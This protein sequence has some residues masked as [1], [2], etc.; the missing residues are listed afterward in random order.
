MTFGSSEIQW[1]GEFFTNPLNVALSKLS[2]LEGNG[3]RTSW[4]LLHRCL[5]NSCN[6]YFLIPVSVIAEPEE[7]LPSV[8]T[9]FDLLISLSIWSAGSSVQEG[10]NA[11]LNCCLSSPVRVLRNAAVVLHVWQPGEWN[12][13]RMWKQMP[14]KRL[15]TA[16]LLLRILRI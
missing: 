8:G 16:S 3:F 4:L 2:D 7:R 13:T 11:A 14:F 12:A 1:S 15:F 5:W 6:I 9:V 10:R